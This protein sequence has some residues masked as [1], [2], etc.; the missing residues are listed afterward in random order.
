MKTGLLPQA[1]YGSCIVG[2]DDADLAA[3]RRVAELGERR[4]GRSQHRLRL[5]D[6]DPAGDVSDGPILEWAREVRAA[7]QRQPGAFNVLQ[8]QAIWSGMCSRQV[9]KWA[10][11]RG[12]VDAASLS[13][14]RWNWRWSNSI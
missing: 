14:A 13:L 12:P 6:G 4:P 11:A 3:L 2:L 10:D 1:G 7:Q 8:L 9:A 5:V